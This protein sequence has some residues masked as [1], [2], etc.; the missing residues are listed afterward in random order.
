MLE[1][2]IL[3]IGDEIL[4]GFVQDTNSSLLAERLR[5]HGV[6]LSRIHT[7]PDELAA[8]DECLQLELG[9]S[10]PRLILTTG[11]IGPTP[12]DVTFEAIA[13]SLGV[14][15]VEEPWIASR[16]EMA[17][18]WQGEQG[19]DVTDEFRTHMMRMARIPEGGELVNREGGWV[20]GIR[21]DVDGGIDAT[22][23]ATIMI[24]PGLPSELRGI[25]TDVIE[26]LVEG[27][28]PPFAVR[29]LTH[30]FPESALNLCFASLMDRY[31]A[32]KVGSYPGVPMIVRLMGDP[33]AV[34]AA[35]VELRA[36]VSELEAG[37]AGRLR[38]AWTARFEQMERRTP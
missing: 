1:A 8:V 37:G 9:R 26:P 33:E 3:V 24:L 31:P 11:G 15:L 5:E 21:Y 10:R 23:G 17:I 14:P 22:E 2:S 18:G 32:V 34:D 4:G 6:P 36:F 27:R 20:P 28:N 35:M 16:V 7:V 30:G 29:E 25:T 38:E 19:I 13:A 12:D